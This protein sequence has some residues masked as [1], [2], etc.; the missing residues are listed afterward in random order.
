[1][2]NSPESI[3]LSL[4][5]PLYNTEK[6]IP[7]LINRLEKLV[8]DE[9]WEVIFVEDGSPD[10][11]YHEIKK[12]LQTA[13]L[14][15][16]LIRHTRNFGEHQAVVTG[17]RHSN[18][19][20]VVNIDDDLQNPPEEAI[21]LWKKAREDSLDAVYANFVQDKKH[22]YWRNIGSRFA[23]KT[24]QYI[25]GLPQPIYLASFRCLSRSLAQ[26][27]STCPSPYTYIDG[28]V[29]QYTNN[30]GT[31]NVRHESRKTGVS[32]YNLKRLISLWMVIVTGF[33]VA[34]LRLAS[35]VGAAVLTLGIIGIGLILVE[36]L[37]YGTIVPGWISIMISLFFFGGLQCFLLGIVGE[38]VGRIFLTI[39]GK[40]QSA[41]KT[42]ESF[43]N[44]SL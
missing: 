23:N 15:A 10:D 1:M 42:I 33:S 32:N 11:T 31:L 28:L 39:S 24:A 38:Y 30:V 21:R 36:M 27:I 5:I 12:Y 2:V 43:P 22:A 41:V 29:F 16:K 17:Y 18:G 37:V 4:V 3:S 40:P 35:I 25:L 8:I 19:A 7:L 26:Q 13:D 34:P 14:N 44:L 20:Y 6:V 9:P